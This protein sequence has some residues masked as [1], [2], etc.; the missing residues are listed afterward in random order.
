MSLV[1]THC[2]IHDTVDFDLS[3]EEIV[4]NA[5]EA[6]VDRIITVGTD[7]NDSLAAVKFAEKYQAVSALVGVYPLIETAPNIEEFD[8]IIIQYRPV[9]LGD[10]GL[11]YHYQPYNRNKQLKLLENLLNLAQKHDLPVSFHVREAFD[12]F[13]AVFDNFPKLRGTL[14]SYTDDVKNM[15]KGLSRGLYV[16][17]NGILTFN[18]SAELNKV[19]VQVPLD[20]IIFETDAPYLAPAPHRGRKNQPAYIAE[21][22]QFFA[23]K[24]AVDFAQIAEITTKNAETLFRLSG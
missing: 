9:G 3:A 18:K 6:G 12:D 13:W 19:F 21:I 4:Q 1:D 7:V 11:D 17:I 10:I 22:A 16:S 14:H 8:K 24:R 15:E 5:L 23:A 20:R 2:H